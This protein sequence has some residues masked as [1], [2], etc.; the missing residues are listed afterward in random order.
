MTAHFSCSSATCSRRRNTPTPRQLDRTVARMNVLRRALI[1]LALVLCAT[2]S[3]ARA[4]RTPDW[5]SVP[6]GVNLLRPAFW[7][8]AAGT[9][10]SDGVVTVDASESADEVQVF[11]YG[12]RIRPTGDFGVLATIQSDTDDLAAIS[13]ID[14]SSME[15]AWAGMPR[16][17]FGLLDGEAIVALYDGS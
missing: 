4:Q 15:P 17:E 13:L 11:Q 14:S 1:V 2:P 10:A 16:V 8:G 9:T 6:S 12:P 7:E 5:M 3:S